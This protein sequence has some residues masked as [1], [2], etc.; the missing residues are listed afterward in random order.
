MRGS[1]SSR[2]GPGAQGLAAEDV[3]QRLQG[4]LEVRRSYISDPEAVYN[5]IKNKRLMFGESR[6]EREVRV[7]GEHQALAKGKLTGHQFAS[8]ARQQGGG[9][10]AASK[11]CF[12]FRDHENCPKGDSCPFSHDKELRKQALAAKR[13][14][15]TLATKGGGKGLR[16]APKGKPKAKRCSQ[17]SWHGLPFLSEERVVQEGCEL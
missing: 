17:A 8:Q 9:K 14:E 1:G 12:H 4:G 2:S 6:E 15:S 3:H 16:P 10:G 5:R 7:D 11:I 13:G